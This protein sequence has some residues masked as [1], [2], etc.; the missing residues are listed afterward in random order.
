MDTHLQMAQQSQAIDQPQEI[1]LPA[2]LSGTTIAPLL[3][4]V[5]PIPDF[6]IAELPK[7]RSVA[8]KQ[9]ELQVYESLF[10]TTLDKVTEGMN[11]KT[12]LDLDGRGIE[13]GR[14]IRWIMKDE[15]RRTRYYAAQQAGAEI[16]FEEMIDIADGDKTFEDVQRSKL[17]IDTRKWVLGIHDK[18]R[19]GDKSNE[20]VVN[21]NLGE[22][23][24]RAAERVANRPT[25]TIENGAVVVD[26]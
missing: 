2:F 1:E 23:M 13:K 21:V 3:E 22:A 18:K 6:L 17:R 25:L 4:P 12:I 16:I 10:E 20:L 7:G 15:Q 19:F 24:A 14:F 8:V 5:L 9:L 26:G 11:I